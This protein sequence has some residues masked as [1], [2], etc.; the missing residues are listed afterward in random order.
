ELL[1]HFG[2]CPGDEKQN[3]E[4]A[5]PLTLESPEGDGSFVIGDPVYRE[6]EPVFMDLPDL[7]QEG[8]GRPRPP[9][10]EAERV[11]ILERA[12][13]QGQQVEFVYAPEPVPTAP[14]LRLKPLHLLR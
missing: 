13:F 5:L 12:I 8:H 11:N 6:N 7:P 14:R 4:P 9:E 1:E 2:L 3:P 10:S